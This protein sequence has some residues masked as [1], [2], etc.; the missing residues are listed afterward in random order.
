MG[1]D[2]L[3]LPGCGWKLPPEQEEALEFG[4]VLRPRPSSRQP[5]NRQHRRP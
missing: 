2:G 5:D 1:P 3:P 4:A